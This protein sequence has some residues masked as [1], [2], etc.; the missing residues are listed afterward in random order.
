M[1][2]NHP[3]EIL[4]LF[5]VRKSGKQKQA[6]RACVKAYLEEQGYSVSFESGSF[7]SQNVVAGNPKTMML[8]VW[9]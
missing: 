8:V 5:P 7:R 3:I 2:I 4:Q 6:F 9:L 1:K